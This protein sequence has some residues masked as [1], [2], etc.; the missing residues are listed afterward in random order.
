MKQFKNFLILLIIVT[1]VVM[2]SIVINSLF[3]LKQ[4]IYQNDRIISA[5]EK[6]NLKTSIGVGDKYQ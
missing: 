1:V 4:F 5:I 6:L 2:V 3:I